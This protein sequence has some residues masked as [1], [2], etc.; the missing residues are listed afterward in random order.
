MNWH[1]HDLIWSTLY[2]LMGGISMILSAA[3]FAAGENFWGVVLALG[4]CSVLG[5]AIYII[6]DCEEDA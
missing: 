3:S 4:A 5:T 6:I 2:G 1:R